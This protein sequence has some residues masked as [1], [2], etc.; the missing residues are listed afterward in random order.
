MDR[1]QGFFVGDHATE[2]ERDVVEEAWNAPLE[3]R[4]QAGGPTWPA[5]LSEETLSKL[6]GGCPAIP[7]L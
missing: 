4:E 6:T 2:Y 5:K 1:P 3:E 7:G